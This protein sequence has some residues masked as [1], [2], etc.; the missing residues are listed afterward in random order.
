MS[1]P[2]HWPWRLA[3][4]GQIKGA[5]N[6]LVAYVSVGRM[7]VED[8]ESGNGESAAIGRLIAAAPELLHELERIATALGFAEWADSDD[9]EKI[10]LTLIKEHYPAARAAVSKA[11]GGS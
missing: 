1:K 5:D 11:T 9:A 3:E 2:K 8:V 10:L 4:H 6:R 7:T